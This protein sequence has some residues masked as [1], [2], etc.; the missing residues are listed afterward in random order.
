V[1][2]DDLRAGMADDVGDL[3]W[4]Q[5]DVDGVEDRAGF[6]DAVVGLE[7]LMGVVGDEADTVARTD[8]QLPQ[9]IRE[10]VGSLA[11]LA[12]CEL[13]LAVDDPDLFAEVRLCPVAELEHR[14][15]NEHR[16]PPPLTHRRSWRRGGAASGAAVAPRGPAACTPP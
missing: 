11:E 13:M 6:E 1:E 12:V 5:A 4:G 3:A 7:K 10:P 15:G 2:E 16:E 8:A 14:E 9:R